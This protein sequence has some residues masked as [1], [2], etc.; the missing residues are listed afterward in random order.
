MRKHFRKQIG[1]RIKQARINRYKGTVTQKEMAGMLGVKYRTYQNW[2]MGWST[3]K[4]EMIKFLANRLK[5][6]PGELEFGPK[7][8]KTEYIKHLI[9][10][11]FPK[12][13]EK[14]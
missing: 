9:D 6:D 3:P 14:I 5:V 10:T 8:R 7:P 12:D 11:Y 2:E 1:A 4:P 13:K